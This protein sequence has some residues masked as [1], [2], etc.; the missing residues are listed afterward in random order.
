[1][2]TKGFI[3][4]PARPELV[5]GNIQGHDLVQYDFTPEQYA[6]LS[7]LTATLCAVFPK[8]QCDYPKDSAGRLITHKLPEEQLEAY[9]G[10]LGHYH[11]QTDKVDPG[12]A[13]QWNYVING[14]R[15]IL[16]G[17]AHPFLP[18]RLA[19]NAAHN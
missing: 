9:Q 15:K 11:I 18:P 1:M 3:G 16:R 4:H 6:A 8:I 2:Y 7:K 12:P 14:A 5:H 13:F 17:Q 19:G 10:V